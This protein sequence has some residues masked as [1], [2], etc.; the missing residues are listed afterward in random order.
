VGAHAAHGPDAA[1]PVACSDCHQVPATV[2]APGHLFDDGHG[3]TDLVA[4]VAFGA[5]ARLGNVS[6]SYDRTS[7]S[8]TVYC[9]GESLG[10]GGAARRPRWTAGPRGCDGCHEVPAGGGG[11][12]CSTCHQQSVTVCKP[13]EPGCLATSAKVGVRFHDPQLHI[14]GQLPLGRKGLEGTCHAC[15]G[16]EATAGAP[17]PDLHGQT[18]V[19]AVT[20]GLHRLHLTAGKYRAAVPCGSCHRVPQQIADPGHF[21]DDLP[22]EV[23][24]SDLASGRLAHPEADPTASR[25]RATATCN[26]YCHSLDGARV[27][28]WRWTSRL[29]DGVSCG[30]C[31]G[32]PPRRLANGALHTLSTGCTI[33]HASAYG[34]DGE[35]DPNKHINGK[36]DQ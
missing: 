19:T 2:D 34:P 32:L 23:V 35:L 26:V 10:A 21:D 3:T 4:E 25:D 24:F 9:H 16:S 28:Q 5:R 36:V 20:V 1:A 17:A 14:D 15:H 29:V 8:C 30:A 6:P 18:A 27:T 7:R 31:H 11:P 22:A 13:G 33:C 12:D